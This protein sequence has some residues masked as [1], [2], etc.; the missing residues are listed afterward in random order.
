MQRLY[1]AGG[2]RE[3]GGPEMRGLPRTHVP[4]FQHVFHPRLPAHGHAVGIE[5]QALAGFADPADNAGGVA[6]DEGVVG[7][8][9]GH[10]GARAYEGVAADAVSADDGAVGAERSAFAHAG[11]KVKGA[12]HLRIFAAGIDDVG[13]HHRG[14]AEH[15]IF[16]DDAFVNGDV[17]LNLAV[18]PDVHVVADIHILPEHTI[19]SYARTGLYMRV[20]PD[21][22]AVADEHVAV[23]VGGFV[24]EEIHCVG[25][26]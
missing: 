11:L 5:L 13:E 16:E 12:A 25:G 24:G 9:A 10:D 17:V 8:V 6:D 26:G 23:D 2:G 21:L 22:R 18:I 1:N 20:M 19:L 7:D 14:S 3:W 4:L 15:V